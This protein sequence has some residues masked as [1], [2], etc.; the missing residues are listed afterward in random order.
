MEQGSRGTLVPTGRE[1]SPSQLVAQI[2]WGN[3]LATSGGRVQVRPGG[4]TLPVH[5]GYSVTVDLRDDDTYTVRRMFVRAGR[6]W[7][8]GEMVRV[9][10]DCVGE[11]VY[12][13]GCFRDPF[14]SVSS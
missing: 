14:G 6:V 3:V 4:V 2:G 11:A 9:Y 1:F 8:K 10:A 5:Y 7:C 12:R 13:A